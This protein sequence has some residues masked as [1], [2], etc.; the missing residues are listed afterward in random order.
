MK[1]AVLFGR[2]EN[3][4]VRIILSALK[5]RNIPAAAY[6]I[7]DGWERIAENGLQRFLEGS[8]H[9]ML[10]SVPG[11]EHASWI[12]FS[13]GYYAG[14]GSTLYR[15]LD[16]T[17]VSDV[18]EYLRPLPN[19]I[20]ADNAAAYFEDRRKEWQARRR[21]EEAR[22]RLVAAGNP[23]T[24]EGLAMSVSEGD[25]QAVEDYFS[26]GY[27]PDTVNSDG[28]PLICT[29]ARHRH[30]AIVLRLIRSGADP[31]TVSGDRG[32][33]ALMDAASLGEEDIA[34]DL[35]SAGADP[36]VQSRDGQTALMVAIG[37]GSLGTAERLIRAGASVQAKDK[38]GMSAGMY[39]KLFRF[40]S[41]AVMIEHAGG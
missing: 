10:V 8:S 12:P 38:L 31:N 15:Y 9:G 19:G 40:E 27:S 18:P 5:K 20:G 4:V 41:I 25:L 39:A 6:R 35:I 26:V 32:S 17:A 1:V 16:R 30:R 23:L 34:A 29:A 21:E 7:P 2:A 11:D 14:A 22:E 28:V 36:D 13:A 24:P 33:T 37:K 3:E